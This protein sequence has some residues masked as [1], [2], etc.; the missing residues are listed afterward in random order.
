MK[1]F[2][3]LSYCLIL[4][5][6]VVA[7]N[8]NSDSEGSLQA[9]SLKRLT[10]KAK[11]GVALMEQ[12][13]TFSTGKGL[14]GTSV[15]TA[16]EDGRVEM[17]SMEDKAVVGYLL[18]YNQFLKLKDYDFQI[19]YKNNFKTQKYP[20]ERVS[21]SDDNIFLDDN[22]GLFYGFKAQESGTR[23]R[24][25]YNYEY[26]DAK[27]LTRI[28]FHQHIPVLKHSVSF[29]VP[30]WL[31]LSIIEKNFG[32]G[33]RIKKDTKKEKDFTTYT[34]TAENL[35]AISNEPS[36]LGRPF[37]LPHLVVTVRSF[38]INKDKFS[39]FSNLADMYAWYN[40]LYKKAENNTDAIKTQVTQLTQ[41][42]SSDEEKIKSIYYW[43]QDNIRYIA[44]E[45]GY[46]GFIPQTVQDVY[47]NKY[48]DCKGMANLVT[49]MLKIAGYDAHFAWIGT[50]D[51]PYD[52]NEIQSLCVDNHAISVLYLKGKPYFLDGTE[53]Y[54]PLGKNAYR[55]QGK[56]VLVQDGDSYKVET[57]PAATVD[58]NLMSTQAKFA[59]KGDRISGKVKLTFEGEARNYFHNLYNGIPADKRKTFIKNLVELGSN[60]A[61]AI[62]VKT[63]DFKNRDIPL[64]I[65]AD[66][67][68]SNQVTHVDKIC[69][70]SID[71]VPASIV[72]VSPD[73]ERQNPY[74]LDAVFLAK[75]EIILELPAGTK[76]HS[77]PEKFQAA[78]KTNNMEAVYKLEGNQVILRKTLQLNSP[79]IYKTDFDAWKTFVNKIK[80]FNRTNIA[81][82]LP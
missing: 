78:F 81:L 5:L 45:E 16:Q 57:V 55:I 64:V 65:E 12:Q 30:S 18:P 71:F 67:E 43:V 21:L 19:F 72:K 82:Q 1:H 46:A 70:T 28:F 15:V 68:L 79:V 17:V 41:G 36:S 50:R 60:N 76:A 39:G 2:M 62:N 80:E 48:G 51:I 34:F 66:V 31:E 69:Y 73:N 24:F 22:F 40:F 33:Y 25:T 3:S 6:F 49:E 29:K 53:K 9:G 42:K 47:K 4:S 35:G 63:S 10:K 37:Y 8:Q 52:R 23:S 74:D 14:A 58:E 32:P 75:D 61:E 59:L 27:Y 56:N 26:S 7:Q 38:T 20:A 77:L 54:A 13:F 11:Y 44:F